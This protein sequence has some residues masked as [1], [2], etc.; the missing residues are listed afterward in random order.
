MFASSL[1]GCANVEFENI[2][3][4]AKKRVQA[5]ARWCFKAG[6]S[7]SPVH[8]SEFALREAA[9]PL[10]ASHFADYLPQQVP[11]ARQTTRIEDGTSSD[12]GKGTAD[13]ENWL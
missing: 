9:V 10:R 1:T 11:C 8:W 13:L 3:R 5:G 7:L 6:A 2:C 4:C 12:Q